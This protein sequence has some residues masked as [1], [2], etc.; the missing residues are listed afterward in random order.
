M[1]SPLLLL[2]PTF[3]ALAL[4]SL[5]AADAPAAPATATAPTDQ[6]LRTADVAL[7]TAD[8]ARVAAMIAADSGKLAAIFSD[9][10]HYAHA[11][12][13]VDTKSS[14]TDTLTSGR[15]KYLHLDYEERTFT[16]PSPNIALM[17]GRVHAQVG[18][19]TGG[20]DSI[21]GFLAV[22]RQENGQWRFLAW[23]SCKIPPPAA[24]PAK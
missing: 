7:R 8:D 1:K 9:D 16:Y 3:L 20:M 15:T 19:A 21:L 4:V 11:S 24:S 14:L 23:Q 13:A 6:D 17:T 22:W 18:N 5:R 2:L 10:L 12:G